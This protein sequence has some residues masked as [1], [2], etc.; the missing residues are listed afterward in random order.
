MEIKHKGQ[1][2]EFHHLLIASRVD[3]VAENS[4]TSVR[5]AFLIADKVEI[6]VACRCPSASHIVRR[7]RRR[8]CGQ[9]FEGARSSRLLM[10]SKPEQRIDAR[11]PPTEL[12]SLHSSLRSQACMGLHDRVSTAMPGS[13]ANIERREAQRVAYIAILDVEY[14]VRL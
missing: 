5:D 3:D 6:A 8:L 9:P 4:A 11:R 14:A 13:C 10:L 12:W 7:S 2:M 1:E